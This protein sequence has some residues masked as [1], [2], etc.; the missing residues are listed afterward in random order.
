MNIRIFKSGAIILLSL[1]VYACSEDQSNN[2]AD[3]TQTQPVENVSSTAKTSSDQATEDE[4]TPNYISAD[5]LNI[6]FDTSVI[7][8][9]FD[10]RSKPSF[11]K[12]H[13]ES[14]F[15]MPY[16]KTDDQMLANTSG[17]SLDSEIITYCGCP[18]HLSTL[19]AKDLTERGYTNVKV[20]YEGFWHWKDSGYP[21]LVSDAT[22]QLTQLRFAGSVASSDIPVSGIDIF[23]KHPSGQL[24]A[25]ITDLKGEF[26]I[27]FHL[28]DYK[29]ADLFEII[30]ADINDSPIK[31]ATGSTETV[32]QLTIEL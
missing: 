28:Y 9:I 8:Y 32:N 6:R 20:L 10:V 15:S 3:N 11:E 13:I 4:F 26:Q 14:S 23:L 30:V 5:E 24:E 2:N 19:S 21:T 25:A 22:A 1:L 12:S 17:L 27:E 18:R 31:L 29:D 7:P 16:G